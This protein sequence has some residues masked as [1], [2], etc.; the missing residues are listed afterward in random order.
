MDILLEFLQTE[1]LHKPVWLWLVFMAVVVFLLALDLGLLHKKQHEIGIK[2]SLTFSAFYISMGL[3]FGCWVWWYFGGE[4]GLEYFTGFLVEKSLSMDNI[5]VIA[6][7]FSYFAIPR[8]YQHRVLFYGILG[9]LILR[10][11]MIGAGA[12]LVSEFEWVLYIFAAF[13]IYSGIKMLAASS[14]DEKDISQNKMLR[15]LRQHFR[16]T[17]GLYGER[18]FVYL[19]SAKRGMKVLYMTP[20]FV[21]LMMIEIA[22]IVF[23]V[24]SVPAIF[25]IT[26]DPYIVYTSNV[27]AIL[28][29]RALFFALSAMIERFYYLKYAL[30]AVLIF[31]GA[32]VFIAEIFHMEKFPPQLSLGITIFI[33]GS[34]FAYSIW[35]TREIKE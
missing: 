13:L 22:D 1:F 15:F 30:S 25:S 35:K 34:G 19:P 24:D 21:S 5:F 31:I 18:F 16:T 8:M 23:A 7:I 14:E 33:L 26:T 12:T 6:M 29:L 11:I 17:D 27:F 32:K 4:I 9:A 3:L 2:E 20:L 28:G 10:G